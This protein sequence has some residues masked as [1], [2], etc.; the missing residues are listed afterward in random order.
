MSNDFIPELHDV[1]KLVDKALKD[2]YRRNWGKS[3]NGHCFTDFDFS[4]HAVSKPSSPSWWGQFHHKITVE[5][6]I[7]TWNEITDVKYRIDL[8]LLKIADG[9]ASSISRATEKSGGSGQQGILKLWNRDFYSVQNKKGYCWA[10]FRQVGDLETLFNEIQ[11]CSSGSDFLARYRDNLLLTPEDKSV[12]RNITSLFTHVELVGKIYRV[13]KKHSGTVYEPD[14]SLS[15]EYN[16]ETVRS[17]REAIGERNGMSSK[18]K[19]HAKFVKCRIRFPHSFVR[20]SDVNL[21]RRREELISVLKN[22]YPDEVLFSTSDFIVLF[23]PCDADIK[24]IF[25][26]LLN[27]GFYIEAE[28]VR[29]DLGILSSTLDRKVLEA[30]E[31]NDQKYLSIV[32]SRDIGIFKRYLLFDYP[33]RI[34]RPICDICQQNRATEKEKGTIREWICAKCL[35]IRKMGEPFKE[36][37]NEWEKEE[38]KVCWFKFS[39]NQE[40]LVNWLINA[41]SAYIDESHLKSPNLLKEEFRPLALQVD[42]NNEYQE[43]LKAFWNRF[44]NLD[45]MKKPVQSYNEL[46]VFK[47]SSSLVRDVIEIFIEIFER[48][49]PDCISNEHS[50]INLSLSIANI[51]YPLRDHWKYMEAEK[52]SFLNIHCRGIFEDEYTKDEVIYIMEELIDSG[53][54][55]NYLYKLHQLNERLRSDIHL[56]IEV[57]N[58]RVLCP[59]LYELF[60]RGIHPSK[61]LN[62]YK[63]LTEVEDEQDKAY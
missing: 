4:T 31:Y 43:T 12:P 46:G 51:K 50:P 6:D 22:D 8:F 27:M 14:S 13:L 47:Y 60:S 37:G 55:Q 18:G 57:F 42:F 40:K 5:A 15:I 29:A 10:A 19:W 11:R 24:G 62:L 2:H 54:S 21:L 56:A 26:G 1:G 53:I 52:K 23:L 16:G 38:I 33:D 20:L 63:L 45:D 41:F 58:N 28:E 32:K 35:E 39:L 48:M 25:R 30:R 3:W 9:L 59:Q 36:Y 61:S 7:S 17:I 34:E 49:F 44:E